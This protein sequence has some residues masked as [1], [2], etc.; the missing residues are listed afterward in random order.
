MH[1]PHALGGYDPTQS[2]KQY[3]INSSWQRV[4]KNGDLCEEKS[5]NT[6]PCMDYTFVAV[7]TSTSPE[8]NSSYNKLLSRKVGFTNCS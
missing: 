3:D 4:M 5:N 2:L 8:K 6:S 7:I 1:G